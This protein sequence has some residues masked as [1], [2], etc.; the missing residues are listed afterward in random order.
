MVK[1]LLVALTIFILLTSLTSTALGCWLS[2]KDVSLTPEKGLN[3][4]VVQLTIN[5]NKFT[6][7][8]IVK[9][10][11]VG[12][13][14]IVA[15][16]VQ[17]L[18]KK[19]LVCF[20]DLSQKSIGSWDISITN[21]HWFLFFKIKRTTIVTNGF[22]VEDAKPIVTRIEPIKGLNNGVIHLD[23]TG[24][25][26]R[27]GAGVTLQCNAKVIQTTKIEILS[28]TKISCDCNLGEAEPGQYD[29][30][31]VN[32]DGS[33]GILTGSFTVML[34][35][36][37]KPILLV[38]EV[39]PESGQNVGS[40]QVHISGDN[41]VEGLT[42]KLVAGGD[43]IPGDEVKVDSAGELNCSFDLTE[44]LP[45]F[46]DLVVTNPDGQS[47]MIAEGFEVTGAKIPV[48]QNAKLKPV[49]FDFDRW[50][51]PADQT[52]ILDKN[53]TVMKE[54]LELYVILG[55]HADERGTPD[56][57]LI[58]AAKRAET[59]KEYLVAGG[60]A[61][62]RIVIYTYGNEYPVKKGHNED[63]WQFNRR[64]DV[65]VW[66]TILTRDDMLTQTVNDEGE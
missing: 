66:E 27:P 37:P 9:L 1:K 35:E 24:T 53:I 10:T 52:V 54:N 55:G 16:N 6:K 25:N 38:Y 58:L 22:M 44:E 65:V 12:Q 30:Q 39:E 57:N 61:P 21:L 59:V 43:E 47:D 19:Q 36:K 42:V 48:S 60:I 31:V 46:Y 8:V 17:V 23:I 33:I 50:E 18:S 62:E 64:V 29:L 13:P 45:G 3:N 11:K 5:G 40:T 63:A 28:E 14:D 2:P 15:K 41:F 26:F 32:T 34:P 7:K 4:Q 20:V 56:Y 49:F 51:L